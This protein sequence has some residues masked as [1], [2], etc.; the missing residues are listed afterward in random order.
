LLRGAGTGF[1]F[2]V[3]LA[4]WTLVPAPVRAQAPAGVPDPVTILLQQASFWRA[5]NREDSEADS[6]RRLLDL[7]P[8]NPDALGLL[9]L[10]DVDQGNTSE[11]Q[12]LLDRLR[13]ASPGNPRIGQV[14][15]SL[16]IG[17]P[18]PG[19]L[20]QARGLADRGR[21]Q[22]ALR[23]YQT[24]FHG[25]E[26]LPNLAGEYYLT[27]GNT[28]LDGFQAARKSL[29]SVVS[30]DPDDAAAQLSYARLLCL[31]EFTRGDC[32]TRL[33]AL[34]R[35]PAIATPARQAWRETLLWQG[36]SNET[37]RE[38]QTYLA[39][40]KSDPQIDALLQDYRNDLPTPGQQAR[41]RGY[42]EL[43]SQQWAAAEADFDT[44]IADDPR[45]WR[46]I[47]MLAAIRNHQKRLKDASALVQ[48]A[49]AIKPE[50][51]TFILRSS[52]GD[53]ASA[54]GVQWTEEDRRRAAHDAA[55][56]WQRQDAEVGHLVRQGRYD[57]AQRLLSQLY[58]GR[59]S[60]AVEARLGDIEALAGRSEQAR[61]SYEQ[62]LATQPGNPD[63]A[64][65]LAR[66]YARA[67]DPAQAAVYYG[68]AEA[69]Y[70][71]AGNRRGLLA[72]NTLRAE[73]LRADGDA[74][75]DSARQIDLYRQAVA[76]DPAEPW[77]RLSLARALLAQGQTAAARQVMAEAV[78]S[79]DAAA[80]EAQI[81]FAQAIHDTDAAARYADLL[82]ASARGADIE[83]LR[84][85]VALQA[86]IARIEALPD[87]ADR[88]EALLSLAAHADPTGERVAAVAGALSDLGAQND[89]VAA[90][91]LGLGAT[92]KPTVAQQ[93]AYSGALVAANEP[94][95]AAAL[96]TGLDG[97]ALPAPQAAAL[98][99]VQD[100]VAVARADKLNRQKR[101]A[102]AYDTLAPRLA[103]N[104]NDPGLKLALGRLYAANGKPRA[105]LQ[106][107][108]SVLQDN[109]ADQDAR[110]AAADAA[111]QAKDYRLA[112]RLVRDG[113]SQSP[114][115]PRLYMLAATIDQAEGA[116]VKAIHDLQTAR[117]LRQRELD[118][119]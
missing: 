44:A 9:A 10:I 26:P 85:Q 112:E 101:P 58:H 114:E 111:V 47:T 11:A 33:Q 88:R 56:A 5:Q 55:A 25:A 96:I 92:P 80:I 77:V 106:I 39:E 74:S 64:A 18:E 108:E 1:R 73:E 93:V 32:L 82:P 72:M 76:I 7:A 35:L 48:Q 50:Q 118:Q 90:V 23:A 87:G 54:K 22:D 110:R 24:A 100:N 15:T 45:D 49:L 116:N 51:R 3:V 68:Q 43:A 59:S 91:Q 75:H 31:R 94:E 104:P 98:D 30:A 38:L 62:A 69:G 97:R 37:M 78:P 70:R 40:N 20:A 16:R 84:E 81:Y 13:R 79:D 113:L 46:S 6:L 65:G 41:N 117:A 86:E 36:P 14:T 19:A 53:W 34:S 28:G 60:A 29:A 89:V 115:D 99:D 42:L 17:P 21:S 71:Q 52:G 107:S 4:G 27:M 2:L 12:D 83:R 105:A 63:A 95:A 109:A 102:D 57:A 103:E 66:L 61:R 8:A 67:G 119:P